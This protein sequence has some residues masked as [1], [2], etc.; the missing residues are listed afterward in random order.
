MTRNELTAKVAAYQKGS[1]RFDWLYVVFLLSGIV[2]IGTVGA[3]SPEDQTWVHVICLVALFGFLLAQIPILLG[4][5]KRRSREHGLVCPHCDKMI[6]AAAAQIAVAS[7]RCCYCGHP[8][9][10][11]LSP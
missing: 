11:D 9:I 3:R 10:S 1:N 2:A 5:A 8:L 6:V 7:G 4:I